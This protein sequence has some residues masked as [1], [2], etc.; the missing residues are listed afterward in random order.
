MRLEHFL[1]SYTT[2]NS[3]QIKDLD[4][5]PD[6]LKLLGENI[7]R[8]LFDT[9]CSGSFLD[10]PPNTK[11]IKAKLNKWDPIKL[12]SF[13]TPTETINKMK[14]QPIEWEKILA[15]DMTDKGLKSKIYKQYI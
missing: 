8:T 5:R 15:N 4:V 9:N 10:L 7:G 1:T 2:I 6:T 14:R 11:E 3:K 13:C 12:K